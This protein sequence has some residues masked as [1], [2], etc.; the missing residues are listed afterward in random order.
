MRN[1]VWL[2]FGVAATALVT[3]CASGGDASATAA[4]MAADA[5]VANMAMKGANAEV[6]T[7]A[8]E[9]NAAPK[10][11]FASYVVQRQ[12]VRKANV[13]VRVDDVEKAEKQV[14]KDVVAMNG[15]VDST[16]SNDLTSE[17]PTMDVTVRIPVARFD[18]ALSS[19]EGLGT[20]LSKTV[21]SEDVTGQIVDLDARLKTLNATESTYRELL[22]SAHELKNVIVLQDKLTEVRSTI[23]SMTAQRKTL[24]ELAALSTITV[25]FEQKGIPI[26]PAQ[27]PSWVGQTWADS[28]TQFGNMGRQAGAAAIW[29]GVF[30]PIWIPI[31]LLL[32]WGVVS[33]RKRPE[34]PAP[35]RVQ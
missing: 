4:P 8:P 26:R 32:R 11:Q 24:G 31:L 17:H 18:A 21:T 27:D 6:S 1:L 5:P 22:L 30:C 20:Q 12:I 25:H 10:P 15:Y 19:F 28:T 2:A 29:F 3:G 16:T 23:E 34:V 14:D 9:S 7:P 13:S 33:A 35:P